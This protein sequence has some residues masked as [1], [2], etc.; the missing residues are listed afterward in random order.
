[1]SQSL[2]ES[3]REVV[4]NA[5]DKKASDQLGNVDLRN[6]GYAEGASSKVIAHASA[7]SPDGIK[8]KITT[9]F[10]SN[11]RTG[12]HYDGNQADLERQGEQ[13]TAHYKAAEG[14]VYP[15]SGPGVPDY[16]DG[17]VETTVVRTDESGN[18][19]YRHTSKDPAF[20]AKV[21]K[22]AANRINDQF[23]DGEKQ[24]AA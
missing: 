16:I 24:I 9:E 23:D 13:A 21:G 5:Q 15:D 17:G 22:V 3:A 11:G 20:A 8:S 1:M 7:E 14:F 18:E 12:S 10:K 4:A 19:V 2:T 6:S